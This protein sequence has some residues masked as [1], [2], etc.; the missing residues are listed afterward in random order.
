[1]QILPPIPK[2]GSV[3]GLRAPRVAT[4]SGA[5]LRGLGAGEDA[6]S[7]SADWWNQPPE[8]W[9]ETQST[10][11]RV[12]VI[13]KDS[14]VTDFTVTVTATRDSGGTSYAYV[15]DSAVDG[16]TG[17]PAVSNV[18]VDYTGTSV[19]PRVT[20][21]PV[22]GR[23]ILKVKPGATVGAGKNLQSLARRKNPPDPKEAAAIDWKAWAVG[24]GGVAVSLGAI[25][26][27]CAELG[28]EVPPSCI[29]ASFY[30]GA[31]PQCDRDMAKAIADKARADSD[32]GAADGDTGG[33]GSGATSA[34]SM[35]LYGALAVGLFFAVRAIASKR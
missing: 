14:G 9:S 2:R 13:G 30:S 25:Y 20:Q 23:I 6:G 28:I 3:T 4:V 19:I 31:R 18:T 15:Y 35:A 34:S 11:V 17:Q 16:R 21:D 33:G 27:K 12:P 29:A 5:M 7:G 8:T 22:T 26:A 1:M 10:A 24:A 32:R